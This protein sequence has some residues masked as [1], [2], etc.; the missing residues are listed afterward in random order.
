MDIKASTREALFDAIKEGKATRILLPPGQYGALN[1]TDFKPANPLVIESEDALKP[2]EFDPSTWRRVTGV[3]LKSAA[4]R[5]IR[6]PDEPGWVTNFT[7]YSSSDF[8][9]IDCL[10]EGTLDGDP[11]NDCQGFRL[12]DCVR[13]G[14]LGNRVREAI[15][16]I[17]LT[18]CTDSKV[19]HSHI[20]EVRSDGIVIAACKR[21]EISDNRIAEIFPNAADHPDGIQLFNQET[22]D[23]AGK[24]TG[25][26]VCEDITIQNNIIR[27]DKGTGN[28]GIFARTT[29]GKADVPGYGFRNFKLHNNLIYIRDYYNGI[30]ITDVIDGLEITSNTVISPTTD[31]KAAWIRLGKVT[32]EILIADNITDQFLYEKPLPATAKV[33][34]N[35]ELNKDPAARA[36]LPDI[37]KGADA[38]IAGLIMPDVGYQP[39]AIMT[40][41]P[42]PAQDPRDA[43]IRDLTAKVNELT[44]QLQKSTA[45][46]TQAAADLDQAKKE[47]KDITSELAACRIDLARTEAM[48]LELAGRLGSIRELAG[49]P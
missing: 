6:K 41:P 24:V 29:A 10:V 40:V 35:I 44:E 34:N 32:G 7:I 25:V 37:D 26:I 27:Q 12:D 42:A 45:A 5:R 9:L 17:S 31:G 38:R 13:A 4:F 23:A 20:N 14:L 1:L 2:A 49:V 30:N 15:V 47:N 3:Y 48:R 19:L 39:V 18:R 21:M 22:K 36:K 46:L 8:A 28:Q 16:A 11:S 43:T 33:D